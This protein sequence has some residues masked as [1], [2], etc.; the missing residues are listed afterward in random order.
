LSGAPGGDTRERPPSAGPAGREIKRISRE[1]RTTVL[2]VTHDQDEAL[3]L[4][5]R[6]AVY[7]HGRVEQLG[8]PEALYE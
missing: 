2:Y 8:E 6:I 1:L 3:V 4:S 5:D 7:N